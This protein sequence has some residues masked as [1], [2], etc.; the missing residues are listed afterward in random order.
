MPSGSLS[1]VVSPIL[2]LFVLGC[3]TEPEPISIE[4]STPTAEAETVDD[5]P[6]PSPTVQPTAS[7]GSTAAPEPPPTREATVVKVVDGDTFEVRLERGELAQVELL[8]MDAPELFNNRPFEYGEISDTLCL[9][10]LGNDLR[11]TVAAIVEGQTVVLVS[12]STSVEGIEP[13]SLVAYVETAEGVDLGGMLVEDGLARAVTSG[14][15]DREAEYVGLQRAA[16]RGRAGLWGECATVVLSMEALEVSGAVVIECISYRGQ[17]PETESDE[18]VQIVNR[19]EVMIFIGESRVL[20]LDKGPPGFVFPEYT[21]RPGERIRVYTN[22]VHPESGG[23]SFGLQAP[24]WDNDNP[25]TAALADLLG[26]IVSEK[27]YPPGC[28]ADPESPPP[29]SPTS[30]PAPAPISGGSPTPVAGTV[31]ARPEPTATGTPLPRP[32]QTPTA[33]VV[34]EMVAPTPTRTAQAVPTRIAP[35]VTPTRTPAASPPPTQTPRPTP[36]T[37]LPAINIVIECIFYNGLVPRNEADEYVQIA[38]LGG[39][40][41]DLNGWRVT[42]LDEGHPSLV[43][44]SYVLGLGG[45]VRV[46]TN[47]IHPEWGGFSF[48]SGTAVWNNEDS[49]KAGLFNPQAIQVSSLSYPPGC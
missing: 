17:V 15:L 9:D 40:P 49:D 25:E 3:A 16:Q 36:T 6:A 32:S 2:V 23:F 34:G 33:S 11:D 10:R 24:L 30:L 1:R 44:P 31:T 21:I 37:V 28:E 4:A 43:F 27:S 38:N 14:D 22:E 18:Y 8:G 41:A 20:N 42:D 46:Y 5:A 39:S 48:G 26:N 7:P 12:N 45:R 19:G 35:T 13:G 29:T 47:Q